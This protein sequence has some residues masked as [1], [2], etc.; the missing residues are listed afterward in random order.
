MSRESKRRFWADERNRILGRERRRRFWAD[1]RNQISGRERIL[2]RREKSD[3]GSGEQ[4]AIL[5]RGQESDFGSRQDTGLL[6]RAQ[7][8]RFRVQAKRR[9]FGMDTIKTKRTKRTKRTKGPIRRKGKG[10]SDEQHREEAMRRAPENTPRF[11][12]WF[13]SLDEDHEVHR[14]RFTSSPPVHLGRMP[15]IFF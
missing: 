9:R 2:G 11:T 15:L 4:T 3:F 6:G 14:P 10:R 13:R 12:L 7:E 5:G 8:Q 1:E